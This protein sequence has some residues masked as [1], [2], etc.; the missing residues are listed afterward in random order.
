MQTSGSSY[1]AAALPLVE[2]P[3]PTLGCPSDPE[4]IAAVLNQAGFRTTFLSA[5]QLADPNDFHAGRFDLVVLPTG[6][7][8]PAKGMT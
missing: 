7:T 2:P 4:T 6:R 1:L 8:F 3:M 5:S